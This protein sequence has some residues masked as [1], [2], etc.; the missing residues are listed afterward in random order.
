ME[1]TARGAQQLRQLD[2]PTLA[3]TSANHLGV[4]APRHRRALE[5]AQ[6]DPAKGTLGKIRNQV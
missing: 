3:V 6:L 2:W 4:P 1:A 5:A